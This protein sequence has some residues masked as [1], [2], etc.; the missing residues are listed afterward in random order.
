MENDGKLKAELP[1]DGLTVETHRGN[2][3]IEVRRLCPPTAHNTLRIA[4]LT[5]LG[6]PNY[7]LTLEILG[8]SL[9]VEHK[10]G[11]VQW[12]LDGIRD[13]LMNPDPKGAKNTLNF[14]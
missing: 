9:V 10:E 7:D 4:E 11:D 2:W 1:L 3:T 12:V 5:L 8:E 13:W 6:Q 14:K